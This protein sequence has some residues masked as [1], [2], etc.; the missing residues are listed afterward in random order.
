MTRTILPQSRLR[1]FLKSQGYAVAD[2][3]T[4]GVVKLR[5]GEYG[6]PEPE[7]VHGAFGVWFKQWVIQ[8]RY[9]Y[10]KDIRDCDKFARAAAFWAAEAA[11]LT[12]E[13]AQLESEYGAGLA[14]GELW[15]TRPAHAINIYIRVD[16]TGALMDEYCEPQ[17]TL[18]GAQIVKVAFNPVTVTREQK[19]TAELC[20][21]G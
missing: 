2:N 7:W 11:A 17:L 19:A 15:L 12:E 6:F 14:F 4:S 3:L 5:D 10:R 21:L 20:L 18:R 1:V 8:R 9:I 16:R 13:A